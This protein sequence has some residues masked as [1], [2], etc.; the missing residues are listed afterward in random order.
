MCVRAHTRVFLVFQ[1]LPGGWSRSLDNPHLNLS[2]S[3]PHSVPLE[4]RSCPFESCPNQPL[5]TWVQVGG[6]D[7]VH[8]SSWPELLGCRIL[9]LGL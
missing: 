5:S 3:T 7:V 6:E 8:V 1:T 4:T 2:L 9:G